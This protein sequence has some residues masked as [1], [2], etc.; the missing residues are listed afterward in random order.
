MSDPVIVPV[1][2][3]I[4][5]SC[6]RSELGFQAPTRHFLRGELPSLAAAEPAARFDPRL[7][8]DLDREPSAGVSHE[9][10]DNLNVLAVRNQ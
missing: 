4:T 5:L 8:V 7:G 2:T 1:R 6:H 10:L 3:T 9:F